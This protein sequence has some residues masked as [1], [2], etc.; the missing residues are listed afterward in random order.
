MAGRMGLLVGS[1]VERLSNVRARAAR[2]ASAANR[3]P[4]QPIESPCGFAAT[5]KNAV[6][7]LCWGPGLPCHGMRCPF[8]ETQGE[9]S[10]G[11]VAR[12]PLHGVSVRMRCLCT[13]DDDR[14]NFSGSS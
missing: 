4:P 11:E 14:K 2:S 10:I 12:V 9:F 8:L 7:V 5:A 6:S 13:G 3:R 1:F